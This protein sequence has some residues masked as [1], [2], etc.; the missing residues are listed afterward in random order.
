MTNQKVY[1]MNKIQ[2]K[3]QNFVQV[4]NSFI[5]DNRISF[6]AKGLFCYMYSM[7]DS[8][9]FTIQ[10]IATQQ[11]DGLSS[12][13]TAINELKKFGYVVYEKLYSGKGIYH[14]NDEPESENPNMDF[15]IMVKSNAIKNT[16]LDKNTNIKKKINK[17][18]FLLDHISSLN[19]SD[20][21]TSSLFE[22]LD[23]KKYS[24]TAIGIDKLVKLLIRFD[25]A[26]QQKMVDNSIIN[27]Y[28]GIFEIKNQQAYNQQSQT[29]NA[30]DRV[31]KQRYQTKEAE[32]VV[33]DMLTNLYGVQDELF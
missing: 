14:L 6:K 5:R 29:K 9:N 25:F 3:K 22:W 19:A 1:C 15:P 27:G 18:E 24:Y 21:N 17:K 2:K 33:E 30:I 8:W 7:E 4:S 32:I 13:T 20:L 26:T 28:K 11:N 12:I 23:Y 10:S 31:L 16:N